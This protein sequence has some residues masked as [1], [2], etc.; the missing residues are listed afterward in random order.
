MPDARPEVKGAGGGVVEVGTGVRGIHDIDA[1]VPGFGRMQLKSSVVK[2]SGRAA[3]G[4]AGP[5]DPPTALGL[6][7]RCHF[8][9]RFGWSVA[10]VRL[11][12]AE[13]FPEQARC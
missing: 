6:A 4:P 1:T 5:G 7:R 9:C 13:T 2:K 8:S 11:A 3:A 10:S 12:F